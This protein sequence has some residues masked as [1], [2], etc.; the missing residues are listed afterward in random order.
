[1]IEMHEKIDKEEEEKKEITDKELEK[2]NKEKGSYQSRIL[3]L[4]SPKVLI[5]IGIFFSLCLGSIFPLYAIIMNSLIFGLSM[6]MHSLEKV[7]ENANYYCLLMFILA[8]GMF[9]FAFIQKFTFGYISENVTLKVRKELYSK[10]LN[11]HIGWFDE[12]HNSPGQLSTI[13]SKD[14]STI[15]G[16]GSESLAAQIEGL[17][18]LIMSLILGFSFSWR[19]ALVC[20]ACIP[21]AMLGAVASI[22]F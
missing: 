11:L 10:I 17:C 4:T 8:L 21:L 18:T 16:V 13:L 9:S 19:L 15:N 6:F 1:M 2:M 12:K 7:R 5:Y 3:K 22:K 20:V 14:T